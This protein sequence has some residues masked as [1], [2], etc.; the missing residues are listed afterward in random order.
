MR[1]FITGSNGF[2]GTWLTQRL[3]GRGDFVRCLV[4][5]NSDTWGLK[6]LDVE[7][8]EGDVTAPQTLA[9][10]MHGIDVV[11]HLAGVRRASERDAFF[12]VNSEGTR[13]VC[14]TSGGQRDHFHRN[15]R[16]PGDHPLILAH[17]FAPAVSAGG[18]QGFSARR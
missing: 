18:A 3:V 8:V 11:F 14:V 9:P 4:R 15:H 6:G 10:L 2:L 7:V 1:A 16:G 5:K 13:N 12:E 17:F